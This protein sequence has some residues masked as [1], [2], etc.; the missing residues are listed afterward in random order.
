MHTMIRPVNSE[1]S[2]AQLV[3]LE[4][5]SWLAAHLRGDQQA[6]AKLMQAY[7]KPVYCLLMRQGLEPQ[8]CDDLFQE[9]FIKVHRS[10][11][12]YQPS[13]PLS[14]WIFT[15]V[16][17]TLRNHF[18]SQPQA[19]ASDQVLQAMSD[20]APGPEQAAELD[21]TLNWLEQ[22]MVQLPRAQ[23]EALTLSVVK[24]MKLKDI[25]QV[26]NIPLNTLKTHLRRARQA[27]LKAHQHTHNHRS[28]P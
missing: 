12:Q 25:C 3:D 20:N 14:P 13:R 27:L 1:A 26:L 16:L 24:G 19:S 22:A 2:Q 23:A 6:F 7:R 21:E 28:Q 8:H 4:E 10:A 5:R 17:N 9:I 18:R 15:I 11:H